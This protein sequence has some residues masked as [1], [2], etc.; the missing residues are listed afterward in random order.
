MAADATRTVEENCPSGFTGKVIITQMR[1][2]TTHADCTVTETDWV[3]SSKDDSQCTNDDGCSPLPDL[4]CGEDE[5]VDDYTDENECPA[6]R[7]VLCPVEDTEYSC[8]LGSSGTYTATR[9]YNC[10]TH[11]W[12]PWDRS[13]KETSCP[14]CQDQIIRTVN[15][16]C[17][18]GSSGTYKSYEKFTCAT[19]ARTWDHSA[20]DASCTPCED[21]SQTQTMGCGAGSSGTY[22]ATKTYSC[23]TQRWSDLDHS[24]KDASCA[25]CQDGVIR[26]VNQSCG[27][28]SSGTYKS[29]ERLTC[30]TG[31]RT[32]D[33]SAKD[34][35]CTQ[36]QDQVESRTLGCS[37]PTVGSFISTRTYSCSTGNW[38]RWS[39]PP[40]N[41]CICADPNDSENNGGDTF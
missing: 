30:A 7:C 28:G 15:Q 24:A 25:P 40:Q 33:H 10:E 36:C 6:R 35:S 21:Q 19:G 23:A 38:S 32:W 9:K 16:S 34:A 20:K 29:Y 12:K 37:Y 8:G 41:M 4:T 26:T 1:G 14:P 18:A 2:E 13:E 5:R 31:A 22:E 27:P 3:E 17:G 39:V 11:Q